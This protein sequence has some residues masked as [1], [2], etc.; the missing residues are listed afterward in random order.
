L[1]SG[2]VLVG[3]SSR[4]QLNISDVHKSYKGR[5]HLPSGA[6]AM[7]DDLQVSSKK[8]AITDAFF[9]SGKKVFLL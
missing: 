8:G 2:E 5:V 7:I 9:E 4:R 3:I 6:L 1:L